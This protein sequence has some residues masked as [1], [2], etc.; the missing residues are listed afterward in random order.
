MSIVYNRFTETC[1]IDGH[2]Q[3]HGIFTFHINGKFTIQHFAWKYAFQPN[4]FALIWL[5]TVIIWI[6]ND[7]KLNTNKMLQKTQTT[8]F[9]RLPTKSTKKNSIFYNYL[10]SKLPKKNFHP[11]AQNTMLKG[12]LLWMAS[13]D[14]KL[15][16]V[17][18]IT[19]T[20]SD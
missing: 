12:H 10:R 3:L 20:L 1:W 9:F 18:L 19:I 2:T 14:Y 6:S 16:V 17:H 7:L 13:I 5:G 11:N 15:P 4:F 8:N